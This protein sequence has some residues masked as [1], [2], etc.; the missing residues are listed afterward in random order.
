[1][2]PS[3][4]V[5]M[6]VY[7]AEKYLREAIDSILNQT[8]SE[9]E[10]L[11]LNDGSFDKSEEIILSYKD[12]R[13]RYVKNEKNIGLVATLNKGLNLITTKYIAR[14]DADDISVLNRFEI[15]KKFMDEHP[16]IGVSS[17]ALERFGAETA[18]WKT[19][20]LN[21]DIKAALLFGSSIGHAPCI[22]RTS[23]ITNNK[24]QYRD[25][26]PHLEDYDL[27]L[28]LKALTNFGNVP[29][30]LYRYRVA[31]NNV[32][33]LN[34]DSN[35]ERKKQIFASVL[36]G[37]GIDFS[38]EE[39]TLHFGFGNKNMFPSKE[40]IVEY[41]RWLNKLLQAN[42]KSNYFPHS[43]LEKEIRK[44]W[45]KLFFILPENSYISVLKYIQLSGK[46]SSEQFIYLS[47]CIFN[48]MLRKK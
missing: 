18:V 26:Y 21:D 45:Y 44:R 20:L 10:L 40:K 8:F 2:Q 19:P 31:E 25:I 28:R 12:S 34:A 33:V 36:M 4:T 47:K 46:I 14:M 22:M 9:F 37:M 7:N 11:L 16:D 15:Q 39:L 24:I 1:M 17:S 23:V 48:K 35:I 6:P 43:S 30:V 42:K 32:T 5:L 38:D 41:H 3:I 27:W 29:D 13:I